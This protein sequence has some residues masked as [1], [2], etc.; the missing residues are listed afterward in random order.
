VLA[1]NHL[2]SNL[3][4]DLYK[5]IE[6]LISQLVMVSYLL[7]DLKCGCSIL[8]QKNE[9]FIDSKLLEYV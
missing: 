9:F 2:V 4:Q 1:V 5:S 8:K 3:K 6:G 7:D